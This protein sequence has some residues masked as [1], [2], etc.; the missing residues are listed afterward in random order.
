MCCLVIFHDNTFRVLVSFRNL[1]QVEVEFQGYDCIL[2]ILRAK[3]YHLWN[4][5][6][7]LNKWGKV[8]DGAKKS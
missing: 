1:S 3:T 8:K 2:Q 6:T 7:K 4:K 5:S